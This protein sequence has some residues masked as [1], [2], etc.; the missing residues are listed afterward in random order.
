MGFV[1]S[2]EMRLFTDPAAAAWAPEPH[3]PCDDAD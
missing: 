1:D 3:L 2:P